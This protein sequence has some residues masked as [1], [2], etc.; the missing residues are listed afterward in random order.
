MNDTTI[1]VI[2]DRENFEFY[3]AI[4]LAE[5][6]VECH[7]IDDSSR[8]AQMGT[9]PLLIID[10]G[11]D[12]RKG[13]NLLYEIK[14][15]RPETMVILITDAGSEETAVMAFRLGA[16]DYLKKPV[17]LLDLKGTIEKLLVFRSYP[18]E[19]R[20][21]HQ[22]VSPADYLKLI[23]PGDREVPAN[24]LRVIAYK[25]RHLAEPLTLDQLAKEA[26]VSRYHFCR[27]FKKAIGMTPMNYLT[28]MRVE[29]AKALLRKN[30]PV[31]TV[32]HKAGFN[33][34]SNFNRIFK[35]VA[36]L[37]PT[38]YRELPKEDR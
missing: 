26:G 18:Q 33:D 3:R 38:A 6:R 21:P 36:G 9:P 7:R 23:F 22:C 5:Q 14:E 28:I 11:F 4:P 30:S 13:L 16:R 10:C 37:T 2:T 8:F 12:V 1:A 24:L 19:K 20:V 17:G 25:E 32:A 27:V 31:A 15:T 35:K 29:R 34:L